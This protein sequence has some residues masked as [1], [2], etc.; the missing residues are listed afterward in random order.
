M[1]FFTVLQIVGLFTM[2]LVFWYNYVAVGVNCCI[3]AVYV[4]SLVK[5]DELKWRSALSYIA[6]IFFFLS[7][8]GFVLG[9]VL[10]F[11]TSD[12][13]GNRIPIMW[14]LI[15]LGAW[16]LFI[17]LGFWAC[18]QIREAVWRMEHKKED[19]ACDGFKAADAMK[20]VT[21]V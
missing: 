7:C 15:T 10:M 6:D 21:E 19:P 4:M 5:S 13:L 9:A 12:A 20:K 18:Q 16:A 2:P 11:T 8:I 1:T 3:S 17:W 14:I